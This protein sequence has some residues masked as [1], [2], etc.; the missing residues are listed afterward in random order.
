V[1]T[2]PGARLI[3]T[4]FAG[5]KALC[6]DNH[7]QHRTLR[8]DQ[9][10]LAAR[11]GAGA[12]AGASAMPATTVLSRKRAAREQSSTSSGS[13]EG[14]TIYSPLSRPWNRLRFADYVT[15]EGRLLSVLSIQRLRYAGFVTTELELPRSPSMYRSLCKEVYDSRHAFVE[16]RLLVQKVQGVL[17]MKRARER[18]RLLREAVQAGVDARRSKR[19]GQTKRD[20][21]EAAKLTIDTGVGG[22]EGHES[23]MR[24]PAVPAPI[25][26]RLDK[27]MEQFV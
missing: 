8:E 1:A 4:G 14:F 6:D 27:E 7:H 25:I 15:T 10:L 22:G 3:R 11:K 16:S 24:Q 20:R 26:M 12:G 17:R 19:K 13:G 2:G 23:P 9:A 21:T 5:R 18:M